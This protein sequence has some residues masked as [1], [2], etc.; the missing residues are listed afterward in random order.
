MSYSNEQFFNLA[1]KG[2][3]TN[4]NELN[5]D[6]FS[7]PPF[8]F[9]GGTRRQ[10]SAPNPNGQTWL[11]KGV[12]RGFIKMLTQTKEGTASEIMGKRRCFF[13]FNP[14]TILRNVQMRSDMMQPLLQDPGQFTAPVPGDAGFAFDLLF[15]RQFEINRSTNLV[16]D[17]GDASAAYNPFDETSEDALLTA[18]PNSI[19]VLADLRVLDAI[20]GQG[21]S[22]DMVDYMLERGRI[23][24][25]YQSSDTTVT[26][27]TPDTEE[28]SDSTE[29]ESTTTSTS[30]SDSAAGVWDDAKV[31]ENL[32]RNIGNQA[33]LM[34]NPVRVVFSSL[35]MVDGF[36]T[37]MAVNFVKF[38]QAMVPVQCS[39]SVQMQALYIGFARKETFL[40]WSLENAEEQEFPSPDDGPVVRDQ[41][42]L[43]RTKALLFGE[44]GT[45]GELK[46]FKVKLSGQSQWNDWDSDV[47]TALDDWYN[48]YTDY[49]NETYWNPN[50]ED[51][52]DPTGI[53]PG[54]DYSNFVPFQFPTVIGV[55]DTIWTYGFE[56]SEDKED[57][58]IYE[59][60]KDTIITKIEYT[61][62][63][64]VTRS[65]NLSSVERSGEDRTRVVLMKLRSEQTASTKEEWDDIRRINGHKDEEGSLLSNSAYT[66]LRDMLTL[67][68][69]GANNFTNT[70]TQWQS[71]CV[72]WLS[73]NKVMIKAILIGRVYDEGGNEVPFWARGSVQAGVYDYFFLRMTPRFGN[74]PNEPSVGGI[75][76]G[77]IS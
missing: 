21:I 1:S 63:I 10:A 64:E 47:P 55:K 2:V 20:I 67:K 58:P 35:F 15:D 7:N 27:T 32:N 53:K 69:D 68:M 49:V 76:G 17:S 41:E 56:Q 30:S 11:P 23:V 19:G 42:A 54:D 60:F 71:N 24:N 62:D 9:P 43:E 57:D 45:G 70:K 75:K 31:A 66:T 73:K 22:Q 25:S 18:G 28:G 26:T 61:L 59:A 3:V 77:F 65:R 37:G 4:E 16:Y 51:F 74:I 5:P 40:T 8:L 36:V 6:Q 38:N 13:Q 29:T 14:Q 50:D 72:D 52:S 33:F 39:I 12:K 34:P 44:D 46:S 48:P